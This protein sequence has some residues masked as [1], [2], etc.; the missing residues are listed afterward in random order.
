[1]SFSETISA[2]LEKLIVNSDVEHFLKNC[3]DKVK[4]PDD[5]VSFFRRFASYNQP[6]PGA[7]AHLV[8]A[9]HFRSDLFKDSSLPI[10]GN[11]D[12]SSSI[13][14]GIFFAA[15][16]EYALNNR[17]KRLTHRTMAQQV[18]AHAINYANWPVEKFNEY[19][20]KTDDNKAMFDCLCKGYRVDKYESD[21]D[22]FL[23]IGFHLGSE[24]LADIEFNLLHEMLIIS[25]PKFVQ[26]AKSQRGEF[27]VPI[28]SWIAAH[29]VVEVDHF[30]YALKA[31]DDAVTF[32]TGKSK[33]AEDLIDLMLTGFAEFIDFQK[34]MFA[35]LNNER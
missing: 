19:Y 16:D 30:K 18:L 25:H 15:E 20:R 21:D 35:W 1:M 33:K 9:I 14:S 5:L 22:L 13:A 4:T 23:A 6:F 26:S 8:G 17:S 12:K 29:T 3:L 2:G 24:R 34:L 10:I 27:D 28:Y 32:Y 31:A 7:V 11:S